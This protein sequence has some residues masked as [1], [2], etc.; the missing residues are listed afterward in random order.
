MTGTNPRAIRDVGEMISR[1]ID[2]EQS[3]EASRTTVKWGIDP[4][5]DE[6]KHLFAGLEDILG[7]VR[8]RLLQVMPEWA[9]AHLVNCIFYPQLGFL[10]A[11]H[12]D[13]RTGKGMYHGEGLIDDNWEMMF[14]NDGLVLYKTRMMS[15]LDATYGDPY[16]RLVGK[17]NA[18]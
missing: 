1:D 10:A 4:D 16:G 7:Q 3:A 12:L 2:F 17:C 9:R 14:T 6:L 8:V 11:V 15:E 5:L 18:M 13:P